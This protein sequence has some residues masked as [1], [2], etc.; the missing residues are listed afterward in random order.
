MFGVFNAHVRCRS[1]SPPALYPSSKLKAG[2]LISIILIIPISASRVKMSIL[3][4]FR[5]R[6]TRQ[7]LSKLD[8]RGSEGRTDSGSCPPDTGFSQSASGIL[9]HFRPGSR[10]MTS[11]FTVSLQCDFYLFDIA[12]FDHGKA[13]RKLWLDSFPRSDARR[14]VPP[15]RRGTQMQGD[16]GAAQGISSLPASFLSGTTTALAHTPQDVN[17]RLPYHRN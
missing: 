1:A 6:L 5:Q 15:H 4:R 17:R 9:R 7:K 8:R 11:E 12:R 14:K 10:P 16:L 3:G 2:I 13:C